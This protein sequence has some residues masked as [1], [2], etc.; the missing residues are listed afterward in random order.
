M[1]MRQHLHFV[2]FYSPGSFVA[3]ETTKPIAE[4]DIDAAVKMARTVSERHNA[5]PYGFRFSTRARGDKGLDSKVVKT[6]GLYWLGGKVETLAEIEARN[7]PKDEILISNM[8][9][10][11]WEK[12]V[13]NT[14]SW[15]WTMP[16][17][18]GDTVLEV[19]L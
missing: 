14:N 16:L 8:R 15:K 6:S 17:E 5:K 13:V 2:T 4:W 10:N 7:D 18:K 3:E 12:I 11:R 9:G 1:A 19:R